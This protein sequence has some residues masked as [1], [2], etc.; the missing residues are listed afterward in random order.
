M[1]RPLFATI[2]LLASATAPAMAWGGKGHILASEAATSA[3]PTALPEF[4]HRS[5]G[6]L[7]FLSSQPDDWRNAG[8]SANSSEYPDHYLDFEYVAQMQLPKRRY[9]FVEELTRSGVLSRHGVSAHDVG[10]IPWRV[11]EMSELLE[12]QWRIWRGD[13]L[14][15]EERAH[16]ES[17]IVQLSGALAHFAADVSNP[18]HASMH[19][20]GWVGSGNPERFATDCDLHWRFETYF[21]TANVSLE[22]VTSRLAEPQPIGDYFARAEQATRKSNGFVEALYRLDRDGAVRGTGT[23]EGREF[24]AKRLAEG[25]SLIRDLWWSAWVN[26]AAPRRR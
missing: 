23:G 12:Q 17:V 4:F 11:A 9:D 25:A 2:L 16:V 21:V 10:F 13:N 1:L 19:Y 22:D 7:V 20:N 18:L 14:T 15:P 24:A 5:Y 3:L 26:S 8:L 6:I